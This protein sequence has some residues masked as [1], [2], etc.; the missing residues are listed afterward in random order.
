MKY[1]SQILSLVCSCA[2]GVAQ[3]E[4][5]VSTSTPKGFTDDYDRALAQ[6]K[7]EQKLVLADF[8][9]SDWCFWC[10]RLDEE[11][12]AQ[13]AFIREA[14]NRFVLLMVDRPRDKSRL[15]EKA[16]KQ[17]PELIKR[18]KI[19]GFPTVLLLDAEGKVVGETGF[20]GGGPK[21]FLEHLEEKVAEIPDF[22]VWIKPLDR[23][24][25]DYYKRYSA[26]MS[27]AVQ[28]AQ[29]K[30]PAAV[31]K[32]EGETMMRLADE[33]EAILREEEA[34][35]PPESMVKQRTQRLDVARQSIRQFRETAKKKTARSE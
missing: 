21:N 18:Y 16:R 10:Q 29:A 30:G 9:G 20:V 13:E 35:Q 32:A 23:R 11:V 24:M 34:R 28:A 7:A 14:T 26:E 22:L 27:A 19:F 8:S 1:L 6:A 31:T 17:N 4:S 33:L 25:G 15:T 12:F 3:A 2:V 5:A